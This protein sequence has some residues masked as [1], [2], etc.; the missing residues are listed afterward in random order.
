MFVTPTTMAVGHRLV[1]RLAS[2]DPRIGQEEE[3]HPDLLGNA[4][5]SPQDRCEPEQVDEEHDDVEER[6]RHRQADR[7]G[8]P[9]Q[10]RHQ[11]PEVGRA[12]AH[13]PVP[14]DRLRLG[15]DGDEVEDAEHQEDDD[16][17]RGADA[18]HGDRHDQDPLRDRL[19]EGQRVGDPERR[20]P[21][22][23]LGERGPTPREPLPD[24]EL[25]RVDRT[26]RRLA[27]EGRGDLGRVQPETGAQSRNAIGG[28]AVLRGHDERDR[29][30][31][32]RAIGNEVLPPRGEALEILDGRR[33]RQVPARGQRVEERLLSI[34][35][36]AAAD[37]GRARHATARHEPS[38]VG[39]DGEDHTTG[40][41]GGKPAEYL[42]AREHRRS[43]AEG[44]RAGVTSRALGPAGER[45]GPRASD[46][47]R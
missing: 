38:G 29:G 21:L 26:I 23:P 18:G 41:P 47:G 43:L 3:Q 32:L 27:G 14:G 46:R 6:Q 25:G 13:A 40:A 17:R 36:A 42:V 8:A 11:A 34:G 28:E 1:E 45:R 39:L 16:A 9:E 12:V 19:G 37:V 22:E 44:H 20:Q 31:S 33:H 24:G 2:Q 7:A 10:L 15:A 30:A 35:G 5:R 4:G